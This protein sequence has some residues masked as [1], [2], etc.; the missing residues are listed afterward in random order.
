MKTLTAVATVAAL[1]A[2][3]SAA[4]AQGS[5]MDQKGTMG[6]SS[7]R[8]IGSGKFCITGAGGA[9]SCKFASLAACQKAAK[10]SETCAPR[11]SS[12]TGSKN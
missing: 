10:S 11:P 8:V 12:T 4:S 3:I 2:G 6:G 7:Q 5:S 9:L 1:V